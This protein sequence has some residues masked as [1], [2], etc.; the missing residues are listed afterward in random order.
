MTRLK[1][2]FTNEAAAN[3]GVS[4]RPTIIVSANESTIV[5]ICPMEIGRPNFN[6]C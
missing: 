6:V 4:Y 1:T 5:P 3:E 2:L